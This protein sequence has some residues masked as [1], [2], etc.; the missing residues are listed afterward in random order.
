M[1]LLSYRAKKGVRVLAGLAVALAAAGAGQ[2][3]AAGLE[4][5]QYFYNTTI[6]AGSQSNINVTI[7]PTIPAGKL[8]VI[9]SVSIYRFP[10]NTSTLQ[11]FVASTVGGHTGYTVLPDISGNTTNFYPAG[12]QT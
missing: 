4:A 10:A 2:A 11:T 6:A 8:L 1:R 5:V 9:Q 3:R 12:A 7:T